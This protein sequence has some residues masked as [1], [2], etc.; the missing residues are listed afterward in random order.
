MASEDNRALLWASAALAGGLLLHIDR[1]PAWV[2]ATALI[3]LAWRLAVARGALPLPGVVA[4]LLLVV[5]V[6]AAVL[7]RFHTFNGLSA[8]TSLLLLMSG[9]KLMETRQRRD[10]LVLVGAGLFLLLAACLDRQSL[11]R[12]PLYLAETW[13]CCTALA[14]VATPRFPARAAVALSGRT[15]LLALPLAVLLFLFFPRLAGS[16]WA[17][18]RGEEALTGLSDTMSPGSIGQLTTSYDIAFRARFAGSLP[19]PEQ[20][21][22]RGPVLHSFDGETWS[23]GAEWRTPPALAFAGSGYRYTV[24]LEPSFHRF[25]FAL[26]T[27]AAA[28]EGVRLTHDSELLAAREVS[29]PTRFDA[30]SYTS[31][32]ASAPLGDYERLHDTVLPRG[33]NPRTVGLAHE[34]YARAG[35]DAAFV[36]AALGY[37]RNGGFVYS[38]EPEQLGR[39]QIDDFLFRTR[40]GFCGHYASAFT[41]LMRAAGIPARVVTGYLGGEFNPVGG[42]LIVRQS[43]AHAWVEVWLAG[44]GWRRVDPTAVVEPARLQRGLFDL[45]PDSMSESTRLLRGT[46][47]LAALAQHWDAANA[48]WNDRV[49]KFDYTTQLDVLARLGLHFDDASELGWAFAAALLLW[50]AVIAWQLG[51]G[52]AAERPDPLARAYARLCGKLARSGVTR[53][54]HQGPLAYGAALRAAAPQVEESAYALL[55]R[56]AQLRFGAPAPATRASDIGEFAR[57]VRRLRVVRA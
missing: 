8:G 21:Y 22:W 36:T 55:G 43:D 27:P 32:S 11:A 17:V 12:T 50:L 41:V 18:P 1:V 54:A 38:L 29:E 23:R 10:R 20:R 14:V 2:S 19:P 7:V 45:L 49:V 15:L 42:Y 53:A 35:S 26:D 3:L 56:Y 52:A 30:L 4:R 37:L 13:L 33:R 31:S 48:W 40:T 25:W 24:M 16:F 57:A 5:A 39:E 6:A 34:L 46:R 47:W 9:L 51:R 44:R 28:P